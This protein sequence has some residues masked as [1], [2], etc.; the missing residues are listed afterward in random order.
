V[1][2]VIQLIQILSKFSDSA[3]SEKFSF[4]K[5]EISNESHLFKNEE[6]FK[7]IFLKKKRIKMGI[8]KD[9]EIIGLQDLV[10]MSN[11]LDFHHENNHSIFTVKCVSDRSEIFKISIEEFKN[12]L[13]RENSMKEDVGRY[14]KNKRKFI[15]SK[16]EFYLIEQ[17]E[18]Y[19]HKENQG[20]LKEGPENYNMV[21][22]K[23]NLRRDMRGK[24][25]K[26]SNREKIE[27]S[28]VHENKQNFQKK[29][30]PYNLN[31]NKNAIKINKSDKEDLNPSSQGPKLSSTIL[32]RLNSVNN[33]NKEMQDLRFGDLDVG[34][35]SSKSCN[36]L[37][38]YKNKII[39][40]CLFDNVMNNYLD[41]KM[42]KNLIYH[43][44]SQTI[45]F[46][47][48]QSSKVIDF[49]IMDKFKYI[50]SF[51]VN[52]ASNKVFTTDQ[53]NKL[54]PKNFNIPILAK[55]FDKIR[56]NF[57]NT[58]IKIVNPEKE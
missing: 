29:S 36:F 12:I 11:L 15:A 52:S 2:E 43:N 37:N 30:L 50:Y 38:N 18:I 5:D 44:S 33:E 46:N 35:E 22:D 14:M 1:I 39:R 16:L 25:E 17:Y 27:S 7:K 53:R 56:L 48:E 42:N 3:Q 20:N 10:Y 55:K 54:I 23:I 47:Q 4:I 28:P 41:H 34:G 6:K 49:L 8:I 19:K 32:P 31:L 13:E 57:A 24:E 9:K 40:R 21:D 58:K 26:S 45:P 51:V